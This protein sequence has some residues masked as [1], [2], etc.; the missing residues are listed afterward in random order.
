[1][2]LSFKIVKLSLVFYYVTLTGSILV[3]MQQLMRNW[4]SYE[5]QLTILSVCQAGLLT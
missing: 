5:M 4:D 3:L 2:Y 1:M